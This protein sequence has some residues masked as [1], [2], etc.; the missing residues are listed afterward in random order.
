MLENMYLL[1]SIHHWQAHVHTKNRMVGAR[2]GSATDAVVAVAK[3]LD[4]QL[5]KPLS[6]EKQFVLSVI[7]T[8]KKVVQ[9]SSCY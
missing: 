8:F 5:M 6:R 7:A 3:D 9:T 2:H 1:Y 4:S